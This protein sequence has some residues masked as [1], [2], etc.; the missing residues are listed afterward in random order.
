MILKSGLS[1]SFWFEPDDLTP[2]TLILLKRESSTCCGFLGGDVIILAT[3]GDALFSVLNTFVPMIPKTIP[4]HQ[5]ESEQSI[6]QRMKSLTSLFTPGMM[7]ITKIPGY[8]DKIRQ[9]QDTLWFSSGRDIFRFNLEYWPDLFSFFDGTDY[10]I[11]L[12]KSLQWWLISEADERDR[13]IFSMDR[14]ALSFALPDNTRHLIQA[15]NLYNHG[16]YELSS[17][18]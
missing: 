13:E 6:S 12:M 17:L 8:E 3:T 4:L 2:E 7:P 18:C 14:D 1:P 11:R 10:Q 9:I 16:A 15:I 5:D